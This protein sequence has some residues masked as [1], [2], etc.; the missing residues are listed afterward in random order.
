MLFKKKLKITTLPYH[1][2]Q[3]FAGRVFGLFIRSREA[4]KKSPPPN[5]TIRTSNYIKVL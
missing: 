2:F 3:L 4:G 5:F 1:I